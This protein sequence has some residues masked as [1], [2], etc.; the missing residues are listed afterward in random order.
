MSHILAKLLRWKDIDFIEYTGEQVTEIAGYSP[1]RRTRFYFVVKEETPPIKIRVCELNEGKQVQFPGSVISAHPDYAKTL[2]E[3]R[4][5][6]GLCTNCG[7]P[8]DSLKFVMCS[9]CRE[10]VRNYSK[11]N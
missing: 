3:V 8:K 4:K 2:R 7:D 9:K 1:G 6:K 11:K 5:E 10:N